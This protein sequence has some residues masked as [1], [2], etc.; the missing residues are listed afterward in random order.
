MT[1]P[2]ARDWQRGA[3]PCATARIVATAPQ[4]HP[5]RT[6]LNHR[7]TAHLIVYCR[8]ALLG[9]LGGLLLLVQLQVVVLPASRES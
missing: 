9:N 5:L 3:V 6:M 7:C 4:L 1:S 8:G 2:T